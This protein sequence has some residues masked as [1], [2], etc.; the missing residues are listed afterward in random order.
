[1]Q[2]WDRDIATFP[3][4]NPIILNKEKEREFHFFLCSHHLFS[5]HH[6]YSVGK[7][8]HERQLIVKNK[9]L[10]QLAGRLQL[11]NF[12]L[13]NNKADFAESSSSH[14]SG[15]CV[16]A[17]LG[18]VFLDGGLEETDKMFADLA[19]PEEVCWVS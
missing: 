16:E 12:L 13:K 4:I 5:N 19:F 10:S 9:N 14:I 7:L 1:M 2:F 8:T 3:Q 15:N 17:I 11:T 6:D 18:A